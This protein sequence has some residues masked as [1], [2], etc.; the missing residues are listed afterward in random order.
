M[1][2]HSRLEPGRER[3]LVDYLSWVRTPLVAVEP[4]DGDIPFALDAEAR[5][6]ALERTRAFDSVEHRTSAWSLVLD[7][8]QTAALYAT[9]FNINI[10]PDR[11]TVLAELRRLARD[12]FHSRVTRNMVTS[13]YI[14][15]RR[16]VSL[17]G[18]A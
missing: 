18:A 4:D 2:L 6:A 1:R 12:E 13:L 8:D 17:T 11:E 15:R 14:A 5:L 16:S 9:Y 7:P 3:Q 10:R